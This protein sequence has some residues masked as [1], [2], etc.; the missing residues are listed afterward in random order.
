MNELYLMVTIAPRT[1]ARQYL[2]LFAAHGVTV[3]LHPSRFNCLRIPLLA[4]QS[5]TAK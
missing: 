1:S 2:E 4:P 3:T 5:M